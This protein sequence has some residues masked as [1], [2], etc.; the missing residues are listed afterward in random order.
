MSRR[1]AVRVTALVSGLVVVVAAVVAVV[2]VVTLIRR[3]FPDRAGEV[4]LPGLKGT[5]TVLRD[6]RGV[7]QIYADNVTDLMRVEGY[8][9]AQDR[10]FQMDV[11]R[12]ITAGRLSELVGDDPDAMTADE[13]VRTLGWR[14]VAQQELA[15]V[16]PATRTA[17]EAYSEGV[18]DYVRG[19]SPSRLSVSYTIL[20]RAV[21]LGSIEPWTP[22]DSLA[23]LKA[24]AWDLRT[25]YDEELARAR[26]VAAVRD[27]GRVDQL[28]PAYP[29]AEHAP[30]LPSVGATAAHVAGDRVVRP[31]RTA[32]VA[33]ETTAATNDP[34]GLL[35]ALKAAPAQRALAAA[36]AAVAAVPRL[37]GGGEGIGSNAWVISGRLTASGMPLLANDPH[38]SPSMPG[39]WYQV[40]LHCRQV[41][42]DCP[43]DVAGYSF[44][45]MPG[46]VVG[47]NARVAWGLSNLGPDVTDFYLERITGD[48]AELDGVQKPLRTRQETIAVAGGEPRVIT[49]RETSHGPVLSDVI[50]SVAEAGR[51]APS[52]INGDRATYAVSLAWTALQPGHAMDALLQIDVADNFA[53][54]RRAALMLDVPAQNLVYADVD[55]HIGYQAPG[56]I[57]LR[58]PGST[59]SPV[60]GDGRWPHPGWNSAYDWRGWVPAGTLPWVLDPTQGYIVAANQAVTGASGPVHFTEDWDYGFRSQ[61]ISDMIS[62]AASRGHSL[63]VADMRGIQTDTRSAIAPELVPWLLKMNVQDKFTR[64]AVDL[65]RGWDYSQRADSAAA[66]YFNVIWATLLDLTFA[67]EL[68]EGQ[69]PDG[70]DR[71]IQTV[72]MLLK[73]PRDPWWDDR[74]TPDVVESR[75]EVLRRAISQARLQL[76][77]TLGKDPKRWKWGKLHQLVLRQTPLGSDASPGPVRALV[78]DGP[79]FAP[80]GSAAVDAF[81]WDASVGT[82]D[83]SAAPSMRMVVDL[84]D[85]DASRWVNQT[86]VSGHPWDEHYADQVSAWLAGRDY[87]WPFTR[88][89]VESSASMR[90]TFTA[91]P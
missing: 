40:G 45:G 28:F 29:Y 84:S 16:S 26:A 17:L 46:V 51:S 63:T 53:E 57:P 73:T 86:G 8:V 13:V 69:R 1:R 14:R 43:Y 74:R 55:G 52:G 82:F 60:P 10:F 49:I 19:R 65:L 7:P 71:W 47:H 66:A 4:R 44:A 75:D 67:D 88:A 62:A 70:S 2:L 21:P 11:R 81:S 50:D 24:M 68:P 3:P 36:D 15:T 42:S 80:G 41:S 18:N 34:D 61:R 48:Y 22:V 76:T 33:A 39:V 12:H 25:N 31:A 89:A 90:Q 83:V 64:Q 72:R 30:I 85:L 38:L 27:V 77:S 54:F 58:G 37:L 87:A 32:L 79:R 23:W 35:A 56:R 9:H 20:D 78:N 59:G 91:G 6:D 5:V